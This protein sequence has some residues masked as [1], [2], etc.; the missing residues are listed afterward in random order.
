MKLVYAEIE[1]PRS[2]GRE[3]VLVV[4]GDGVGQESRTNKRVRTVKGK[5]INELRGW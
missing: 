1:K 5:G 3:G 4:A 2:K